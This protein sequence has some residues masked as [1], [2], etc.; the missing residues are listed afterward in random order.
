MNTKLSKVLKLINDLTKQELMI[1]NQTTVSLIKTYQDVD[2]KRAAI[3]FKI[4]D[5]VSFVDSS[6]IRIQGVVTK[7]NQKTLQV[8]TEKNYYVN[9]PATYLTLEEKPS[10]KLFLVNLM[11]LFLLKAQLMELILYQMD[12]LLMII[13]T[14]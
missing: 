13:L 12:Y 11:K 2:F 6:G 14:L 9:I 8:T 10:Q 5:I 3:N 7:K 1:L 4:G